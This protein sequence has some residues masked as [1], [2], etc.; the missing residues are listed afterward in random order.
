MKAYT[1]APHRQPAPSALLATTNQPFPD[2]TFVYHF[3]LRVRCIYGARGQSQTK[4][5]SGSADADR[6]AACCGVWSSA[7]VL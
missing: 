6:Y 1:N 7:Y 5:R 3:V 4:T 2:R